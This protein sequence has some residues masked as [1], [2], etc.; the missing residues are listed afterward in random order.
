MA[1]SKR[2]VLV[3]SP[4]LSQSTV[5]SIMQRDQC[6]PTS[7]RGSPDPLSSQT[8]PRQT[9]GAATLQS[10]RLTCSST[11]KALAQTYCRKH[12][13]SAMLTYL[14]LD[15]EFIALSVPETLD[16]LNPKR[17]EVRHLLI[18]ECG[19]TDGVGQGGGRMAGDGAN[20]MD[21]LVVIIT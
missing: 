9:H 15:P 1:F 2:T 18:G 5:I 8:V 16:S 10:H 13:C 4:A 14:A 7:R 6:I 19:I 12:N 20:F 11:V 17:D 21:T 3:L